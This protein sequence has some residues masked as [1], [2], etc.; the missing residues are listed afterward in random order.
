MSLQEV[1]PCVIFLQQK[2]IYCFDLKKDKN[3]GCVCE[4]VCLDL[5]HPHRTSDTFASNCR[6]IKLRWEEAFSGCQKDRLNEKGET[7]VRILWTFAFFLFYH[8]CLG[9]GILPWG[10]SSLHLFMCLGMHKWWDSSLVA[11][12]NKVCFWKKINVCKCVLA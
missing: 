4:C 10:Q 12:G 6:S 2:C 3:R 9:G 8:L 7:N 5:Y 11:F 1:H